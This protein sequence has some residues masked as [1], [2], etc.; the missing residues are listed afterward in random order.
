MR[1]LAAPRV[2]GRAVRVALALLAVSGTADAQSCPTGTS[3]NGNGSTCTCTGNHFGGTITYNN[4]TSAYEGFCGCANGYS[5]CSY[6]CAGNQPGQPINSDCQGCL[7]DGPSSCNPCQAGR[8]QP[9]IGIANTTCI[10]CAAG[11]VTGNNQAQAS[12][13]NCAAGKFQPDMGELFCDN[14]AA[15]TF[16]PQCTGPNGSNPCAPIPLCTSCSSGQYQASAGQTAC[17]SCE[18]GHETRFANG[19]FSTTAATACGACALG[20]ASNDTNGSVPCAACAIGLHQDSTGQQYCEAC[21]A[22]QYQ[23]ATGQSGCLGCGLGSETAVVSSPGPPEVTVYADSAATRCVSCESGE[24]GS[25]AN[26]TTNYSAMPCVVCE[27][28]QYQNLHGEASC[29]GCPVG[30]Y[31]AINGSVRLHASYGNLHCI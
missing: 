31:V 6:F 29:I 24:H 17:A 7:S 25:A 20:T 5:H 13:S 22:G 8:Y 23:N 18:A 21:G 11:T 26:A 19:S 12:C 4:A 30:R 15:G 2:C 3:G 27:V 16:S 1:L 28:G 10:F 14:C 9:D